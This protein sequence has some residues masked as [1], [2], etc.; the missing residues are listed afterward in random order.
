[1]TNDAPDNPQPAEAQHAFFEESA[2]SL[3]R[4]L[5]DVRS[6]SPEER[7]LMAEDL[8]QLEAMQEKLRQGEVHI[9]CFGSINV[10]KSS[11]INA[12]RA[13]SDAETGPI[14]GWTTANKR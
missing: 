4:I 2:R 3:E 6:A 7:A 13:E 10:G 11:L 12:L 8:A 5:E 9:L 14:G 1:M